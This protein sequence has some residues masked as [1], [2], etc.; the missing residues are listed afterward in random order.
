VDELIRHIMD[1]KE[2]VGGIRSDVKSINDHLYAVSKKADT[3]R[4]D[5]N[6]HKEDLDAHGKKAVHAQ[7][8]TWAAVAAALVAAYTSFKNGFK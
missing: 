1:L 4:E 5:L 6:E 8:S 2:S 3:I 7:I